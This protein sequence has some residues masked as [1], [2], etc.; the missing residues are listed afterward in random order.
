M[1]KNMQPLVKWRTG[2][3]EN[4]Y[5]IESVDDNA[6]EMNKSFLACW[7]CY[8]NWACQKESIEEST[9]TSSSR[10]VSSL[11]YKVTEDSSISLKFLPWAFST[12]LGTVLSTPENPPKVTKEEK[13]ALC[14]CRGRRN[15]SKTTWQVSLMFCTF[16]IASD[17]PGGR[18]WRLE[19]GKFAVST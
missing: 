13:F 10:L 19:K 14:L 17:A 16:V 7:N 2:Q 3:W 1:E 8:R 4:L 6:D 9:R 5:C 11:L 18:Q 12:I 15:H